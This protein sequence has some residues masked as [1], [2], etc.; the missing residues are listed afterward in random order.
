MDTRRVESCDVRAVSRG[1]ATCA[2]ARPGPPRAPAVINAAQAPT[3]TLVLTPE[4]RDEEGGRTKDYRWGRNPSTTR[5]IG[6][7]PSP[8]PR[9][10]RGSRAGATAVTTLNSGWR[11]VEYTGRARAYNP[12]EFL[13]FRTTRPARNPL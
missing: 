10:T 13:K 6:P 5:A 8:H 3:R 1:G 2:S 7:G 12:V 11:R 4:S 9:G